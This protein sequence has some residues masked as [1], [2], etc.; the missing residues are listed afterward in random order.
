MSK[1]EFVNG[2]GFAYTYEEFLCHRTL[3]HKLIIHMESIKVNDDM[4]QE[5]ENKWKWHMNT[6]GESVSR[7][8]VGH[9]I[10]FQHEG[11]VKKCSFEKSNGRNDKLTLTLYFDS[12]RSVEIYSL[13]CDQANSKRIT[14][15]MLQYLKN[16]YVDLP[17]LRST[18]DKQLNLSLNEDSKE[19]VKKWL[20]RCLDQACTHFEYDIKQ[21]KLIY[22]PIEK[23]KGGSDQ[24]TIPRQPV[25][26]PAPT[27]DTPASPIPAITNPSPSPILLLFLIL[28]FLL[29]L[30]LLI[31]LLLSIL[32]LLPRQRLLVFP[33]PIWIERKSA[34]K[35]MALDASLQK[36]PTA[37][38]PRTLSPMLNAIQN[39]DVW[40]PMAYSLQPIGTVT[41]TWAVGQSSKGRMGAW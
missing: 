28:L 35:L 12:S 16:K 14:P 17:P 41:S 19:E 31:L 39:F 27:T 20:N 18:V 10:C 1:C 3:E 37:L 36:L 29:I 25:A 30:L 8:V 26:V 9:E 15:K 33:H 24:P 34:K 21:P 32:L 11:K 22:F 4:V 6:E 40:R 5:A 23:S 2:E 38:K 7:Q 13:W